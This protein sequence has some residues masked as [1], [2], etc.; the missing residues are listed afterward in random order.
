MSTRH[1]RV[2]GG[3]YGLLVGDALGVPYEFHAASALPPLAE[4]EMQPPAG[5]RRAHRG[6][7]P[8]TWSD[9]G[10]QALC[11]L[12]SLLRIGRFD[13]HDFAQQLVAWLL[14]GH[15]AVD[16]HVFDVG[17]Q[18]SV[19]LRK[20]AGGTAVLVAARR[21]EQANGNGALMRVLPLALWHQGSDEELVH[22]ARASSLPTHGHIRS[23]LCCALYCLWARRLLD[24]PNTPFDSALHTL[25]T[26][27]AHDEAARSE[28][29]GALRSQLALT[30]NGT[31]YVV[32]TLRAAIQ[33]QS[34]ADYEQVVKTAIALG[35]DT[36]TTAAVAGGIAGLR[37]GINAIPVRWR[38]ALRGEQ[39]LGPLVT[40]L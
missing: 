40:R 10:A 30:P 6:V 11:L 3:L 5:F 38:N 15:M 19:A 24:D 27:L 12:E 4:L 36:D 21:D 16:A 22:D 20:I 1:E 23:E 8:G 39:L 7:A 33:L 34:A 17:I 25:H 31:G 35:T 9:D 18:T 29:N 26:L 32:D 2:L 28:L 13:V 14:D 37:F